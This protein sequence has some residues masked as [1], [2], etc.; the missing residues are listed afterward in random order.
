V[1]TACCGLLP[2]TIELAVCRV[3]VDQFDCLLITVSNILRLIFSKD[4]IIFLMLI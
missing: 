4:K 1:D 2:V 3:S